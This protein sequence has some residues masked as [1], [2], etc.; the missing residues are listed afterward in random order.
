MAAPALAARAD[1][2]ARLRRSL[3]DA[4]AGEQ[5]KWVNG[6]LEEASLLVTSYCGRTFDDEVPNEVRVVTSRVAA[7]GV[8][9]ARTDAAASQTDQA[10]IWQRTIAYQPDSTSGGMWLTK[11][12]KLMLGPYATGS[13]VF[14]VDMA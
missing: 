12:D 8:T 11:A 2:E 13:H 9:S 4:E 6:A 7:R 3:T 1:V 5:D 14:S 10:D